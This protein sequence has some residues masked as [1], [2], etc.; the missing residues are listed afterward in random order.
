VSAAM[1]SGAGQVK[2]YALGLLRRAG[3]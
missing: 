1:N 3:I 2:G